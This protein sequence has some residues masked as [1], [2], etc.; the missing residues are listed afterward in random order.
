MRVDLQRLK[1]ALESGRLN[2]AASDTAPDADVY[3]ERTLTDD[4]PEVVAMSGVSRITLAIGAVAAIILGVAMSIYNIARPG[5]DLPLQLPRGGVLTQA[6]DTVKN[7]GYAD[8]GPRTDTSFVDGVDIEEITRTAGLPAARE[9][10]REGTPVAYWR[11]GLTHTA[12]PSGTLEPK[13]GDYSVRLDPKGQVVAFATGFATEDGIAHAERAKAIAIGLDAIKK[14]FGVDASG[15][16]LEVVERSFPAGKTELTWRGQPGKYGRVE[17]LRINLQGEKLILIERSLQRPRD[18]QEPTVPMPMRIFKGAGPAILAG[19][20][21]IGWGFGLYYLFKMRNWDALTRPLPLALCAV[22]VLQVALSTIGSSGVF[23]SI[24]G[25]VAVS[26]LLIGTVLPALSGVLSWIGRHSPERMWAAEQL[27]RG[28]LLLQGVSAS[29]VDGVSG[30]AAMA[31]LVVFAD[32]AALQVPGFEPSISRELNVVDASFGSM[33]GETLSGSAFIV[34]GVAFA[35]EAFDRFRVNPI[36]STIIVSIAAGMVAGA[37]QEAILP[38]LVLVLGMALAA[39]IV[40]TLHRRR[41]FLAAW[42]AGMASGWLT[43]AMALNSLEDPDLS[44]ASNVLVAMV[45]GIA[46]AGAWGAG[47]RLLQK[48][49][50]QTTAA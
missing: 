3:I 21:V 28:R 24:L 2:A 37:N 33:I 14:T 11:A 31:A 9:A 43:T 19:V 15:Y 32:W 16:E 4:S 17:Q 47:R 36:V 5:A 22:V 39:A 50:L 30:G 41:G 48:A 35:V 38:G 26:V 10:I 18:Y 8:P 49:P 44:R 1:I 34:L 12:S 7:F 6:R 42:I 46:A 45:V 29:L 13:A 25:V 23:Q 40:V 27:A 20:V